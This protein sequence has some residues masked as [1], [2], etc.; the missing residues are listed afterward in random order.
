M[1]FL[2][3]LGHEVIVMTV[4]KRVNA[5]CGCIG[6]RLGSAPW[7]GTVRSSLVYLMEAGC[8]RRREEENEPCLIEFWAMVSH[9]GRSE[10]SEIAE[11]RL[12]EVW[13]M[14]PRYRCPGDRGGGNMEPRYHGGVDRKERMEL[15]GAHSSVS[16]CFSEEEGT[17]GALP[18]GGLK[19]RTSARRPFLPTLNERYRGEKKRCITLIN[20]CTEEKRSCQKKPGE[21]PVVPCSDCIAPSCLQRRKC[22]C[23]FHGQERTEP[24]LARSTGYLIELCVRERYAR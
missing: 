17:G 15:Q 3:L 12:T 16:K 5:V 18:R 13:A 2:V 1:M 14:K 7:T 8:L 4:L 6:R 9:R 23:C 10:R 11:A 19:Y 20:V 22:A 24:F 21:W